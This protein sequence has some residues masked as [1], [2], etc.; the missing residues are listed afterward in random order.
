MGNVKVWVNYKSEAE[1]TCREYP[2][3]KTVKVLYNPKKPS[4]ACLEPRVETTPG[5][6]TLAISF[7]IIGIFAIGGFFE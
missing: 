7:F 6:V 1:R 2:V 4:E 5:I 3:G